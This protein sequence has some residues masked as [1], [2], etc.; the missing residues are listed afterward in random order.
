MFSVPEVAVI[1]VIVLI[2]FGPGKLP[3]IGSAVGKGLKGLRRAAEEEHV[4]AEAA[5]T[6]KLAN[7]EGEE[8]TA[9]APSMKQPGPGQ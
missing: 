4:P 9:K 1:L 2:L 7:S 8:L 5:N 3:D 6:G